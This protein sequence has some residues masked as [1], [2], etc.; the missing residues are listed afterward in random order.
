MSVIPSRA[1]RAFLKR[2]RRDLRRYKKLSNRE[3]DGLRDKLK[4]RPPIWKKLH[5]HQKVCLYLGLRAKRFAFFMDTGTGK[6]LLSIALAR[7]LQRSAGKRFLVLVPAKINVTEWLREAKKHC[8]NLEVSRLSGPSAKK[9]EQLE[10]S[11]AAV[12]VTTYAGLVRM[13]CNMKEVQRRGKEP[14]QKLVPASRLVNKVA[15]VFD[16]LILDESTEASGHHSL[17]FR[18]CRALSKKLE[19]F[20]ILTGTPFG[21]DPTPLWAQLFLVDHGET[22]G[23]TLGLFRAAFFNTTE[24]YWGGFEHKFKKKEWPKL[25]RLLAN[26]SIRYEVDAADLPE[27]VRIQKLVRLPQDVQAYYDKAKDQLIAAHGNYREMKNMFL[28]MRQISSGFLGYLDDEQGIRA[29]YEFTP[30]PKLD[31]LLSIIQSIRPDRKVVVFHDFTFSGSM[32]CRELEKLGIGFAR[33]YGKTEDPDAERERFE[34][35]PNC[36]VIVLNSAVG[37]FGLNL[38]FARYLIFYESPVRL[39]T[40]KQ[41]ERRVE[42][43]G[44]HHE[45]VFIYDLLV[46][47]TVDQQI[48]EYHRQGTELFEAIVNGTVR[49]LGGSSGQ[50]RPRTRKKRPR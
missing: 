17:Q 48:R 26:R 36:R 42:R 20:Y 2:P 11:K 39:I 24:N 27:V 33:V 23:Q 35:D 19:Y 49:G 37:A 1:V 45:R 16:G 47:G 38:Q 18:I 43:Q 29:E 14:Q 9:W 7:H 13:V 31:L 10:S 22:L 15:R 5:K 21:R 46:R 8:P 44:S 32:I 34:N 25:H 40:R 28:R 41:A 50:D 12:T 30:N 4:Y 3:V 6:T